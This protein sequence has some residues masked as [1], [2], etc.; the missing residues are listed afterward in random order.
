MVVPQLL[1]GLP[2]ATSSSATGVRLQV[3]APEFTA[4]V[5]VSVTGALVMSGVSASVWEDTVARGG[6]PATPR[7]TRPIRGRPLSWPRSGR[8]PADPPS[9]RNRGARAGKQAGAG[10]QRN[11]PTYGDARRKRRMITSASAPRPA[12]AANVAGSGMAVA[13]SSQ[14]VKPTTPASTPPPG[15]M[16]SNSLW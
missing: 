5:A 9:P 3:P 4:A 15:M 16:S 6:K 8:T 7:C 10:I 1:V 12:K 2:L 14:T 11:N 13:A